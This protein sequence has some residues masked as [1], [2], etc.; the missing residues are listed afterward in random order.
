MMELM[1]MDIGN[2]KMVFHS[3]NILFGNHNQ[4]LLLEEFS[5]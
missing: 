2:N 5:L 3:K 1:G 4:P